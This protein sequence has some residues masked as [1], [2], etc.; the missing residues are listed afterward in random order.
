MI[1]FFVLGGE[2]SGGTHR[3]PTRPAETHRRSSATR[4]HAPLS[5]TDI[6]KQGDRRPL[7][8]TERTTR[9]QPR[10]RVRSRGCF[11]RSLFARRSGKFWAGHDPSETLKANAPKSTPSD[12]VNQECTQESMR[13]QT[14]TH[15]CDHSVTCARL[16]FLTA[17]MR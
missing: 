14:N 2:R 11:D 9:R 16:L 1:G 17:P 6:S 8:G 13:H 12:G 15:S 5:E 4:P 3:R 7:A 10:N